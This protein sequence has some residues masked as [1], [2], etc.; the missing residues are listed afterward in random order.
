MNDNCLMTKETIEMPENNVPHCF[1]C[2]ELLSS[3]AIRASPRISHVKCGQR[4]YVYAASSLLTD[5]KV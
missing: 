3:F 5:M 1:D 2:F 4:V